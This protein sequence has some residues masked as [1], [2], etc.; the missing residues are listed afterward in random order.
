MI[1]LSR[2][3]PWRWL[4][5]PARD[6]APMSV[7]VVVAGLKSRAAA[8][9]AAVSHALLLDG[10]CRVVLIQL[11]PSP[12][13]IKKCLTRVRVMT[14]LE[15]G[16]H[17]GDVGHQSPKTPFAYDGEHRVKLAM[18][19]SPTLVGPPPPDCADPISGPPCLTISVILVAGVGCDLIF[20]D[21]FKV[22]NGKI[23]VVLAFFCH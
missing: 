3:T 5:P 19:G 18:H 12:L 22:D 20:G 6:L 13:R 8:S 9:R 10:G 4:L 7:V 15:D 21:C 23:P 11:D 16:C 14:A 17:P 2:V 1:C